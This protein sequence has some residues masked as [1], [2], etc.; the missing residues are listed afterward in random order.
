MEL[1]LI[2][3]KFHTANN[4]ES[5][6]TPEGTHMTYCGNYIREAYVHSHWK[7]VTCEQCVNN[8]YTYNNKY[9]EDRTV[10]INFKNN[11]NRLRKKLAPLILDENE[12]TKE[13]LINNINEAVDRTIKWM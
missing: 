4:K 10:L 11:N 2:H 1:E 13:E 3:K 9:Q 5:K 12:L 7:R 8:K 6:E